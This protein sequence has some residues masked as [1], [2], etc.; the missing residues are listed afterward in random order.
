MAGVEAAESNHERAINELD[1]LKVRENRLGVLEAQITVARA[2]VA[3]A[4]PILKP[5]SCARLKMAVS[6]K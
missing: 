5:P 3:S 2:K 1:G 4:E 6:S